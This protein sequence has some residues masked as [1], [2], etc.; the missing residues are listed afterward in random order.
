MQIATSCILLGG[1]DFLQL[2]GQGL[3]RRL[4]G[5]V[6]NVKE[7]A[8]LMIIPVMELVLQVGACLSCLSAAPASGAVVMHP[9]ITLY[10]AAQL[11]TL[12]AGCNHLPGL[13]G[14]STVAPTSE[15]APS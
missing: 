9:S 13:G 7:R 3:A 10:A 1:A 6:G 5:L 2:H 11:Y 12:G 14:A 4:G 8:M 15:C